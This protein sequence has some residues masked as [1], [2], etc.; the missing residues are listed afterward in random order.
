MDLKPDTPNT[1]SSDIHSVFGFV[2]ENKW[3][4]KAPLRCLF[5]RMIMGDK[6]F[7][8]SFTTFPEIVSVISPAL[9]FIKIF[10]L[11]VPGLPAELYSA[12]TLAVSPGMIAVVGYFGVVQPQLAFTCVNCSGS[13]PLFLN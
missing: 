11:K 5:Y 10:L 1:D 12:L 3:G 13:F 2:W 9:L 8:G 6:G 4:F 7:S